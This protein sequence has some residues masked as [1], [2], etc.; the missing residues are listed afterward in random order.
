MSTFLALAITAIL[1][2]KT[3]AADYLLGTQNVRSERTFSLTGRY[4]DPWVSAVFRDNILLTLSYMD[5]EVASPAKID[6]PAIDKP[7][8]Y[9]F[10]LNPG[11]VFAFHEDVLPQ[12]E[13]KV[14]ETMHSHFNY[15]DGFKSDGY[16]SG[17]G[18]C[19]LAS[20]IYWAAKDAGLEALAP[21][22]HDFAVIPQVPKEYGVA[23][24][25]SPGAHDTNALQNL[26]I[27]NTFDKP[28]HFAFTFDGTNLTV[29]VID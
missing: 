12:F 16:L 3:V 22:N 18:V 20:L 19:H 5:N 17:D 9:S 23:I 1:S 14:T 6:W 29:K 28:V 2:T 11:D 8:S 10:T 25:Y 26:Y 15:D 13:G 27:T 21:T 4:P 24:F 7:Q